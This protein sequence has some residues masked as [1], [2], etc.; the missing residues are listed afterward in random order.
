[1][2]RWFRRLN[3]QNEIHP[4]QHLALFL[5][6]SG[7][8]IS[9]RPDAVFHPQFWAEDGRIWFA[10][11]YNLGWWTALLRTYM[12]YFQTLPRLGAGLAL[13]VPLSVAPLLLNLIAIAIQALPVNLLIMSRSSAWGSLGFRALLAATYVALPTS[14]E[15]SATITNSQWVLAFCV[16]L[17]TA[18]TPPKNALSRTVD[19]AVILLSGLTGPFCFFLQPIA[20]YLAY[21][22]HEPWRRVRVC[23]LGVCSLVQAWALLL[24]SPTARAELGVLGATPALF[25]RIIAGNVFLGS[26]IGANRLAIKSGAGFFLFL[27]LVAVGGGV[28]FAA[29]LIR[30]TLNMRLFAILLT[31]MILCASLV[32]P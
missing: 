19:L 29:V 20:V 8:V 3:E 22:D 12:G 32:S 26:L 25:V 1:M 13:L 9:R 16:F 6:A 21:R 7:L 2:E 24:L 10:D 18:A 4:W 30:S 27:L 31:L 11:A 5:L 28:F 15:I 23:L 17:L 14:P